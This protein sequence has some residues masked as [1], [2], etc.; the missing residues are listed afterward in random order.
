MSLKI[1]KIILS[2]FD[3]LKDLYEK[4]LSLK[5]DK[6]E[7]HERII[8]FYNIADEA[9]KN[10]V[11]K[12][13]HE[14]DIPEFFVIFKK[15]NN[16]PKA[17]L[18]FIPSTNHC[19]YAYANLEVD[20]DGTIN[21]CCVYSENTN[22]SIYNSTLS[23]FH[24]SQLMKSLRT[25]LQNNQK[26]KGCQKCW[27]IEESGGESMRMAA[28]YKF[29]DLYYSLDYNSIDS[30]NLKILDLKMGNNCNLSCRICDP[31]HSSSLAD[32][33]L[34]NGS[35]SREKHFTIIKNSKWSLQNTI[36]EQLIDVSKNIRYFDLY[37]GEPLM[38]KN[39]YNYLNKLIEL[40]IAKEIKLDYNSNG[41]FYSDSWFNIWQHFK[42]VKISFSIDNI[43]KRFELERNGS[44]WQK[45]Q[46]NIN[47]FIKKKSDKFVVDI[48]PTISIMNVYYL[49]ELLNWIASLQC[50]VP[51][52]LNN[53]VY[54]PEW[55]SVQ[56][57]TKAAKDITIQ[58]LEK[59]QNS[60]ASLFP[61]IEMLKN[62]AGVE[63]NEEFVNIMKKLDS[64]RNQ[65]FLLT[66]EEIAVAMGYK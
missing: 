5:K 26:P 4:L 64:E 61:V 39:H 6:F 58:K 10:F 15:Q 65:N 12:L 56:K 7:D 54:H 40:D 28:K 23:E 8:F 29:K 57:I 21:P 35:L 37:G 17:N 51:P 33:N 44:S 20:T 34:K 41:T 36:Y 27:N 42:Q 2:D 66:H 46:E 9:L 48:F 25:Q 55:L 16:I 3:K 30:S 45:V 11:E 31:K 19:L 18:D 38:V 22:T 50:S 13:L 1:T 14:L 24:Q 52:T 43:E 47:K 59:Y 60:Y 32:L 49:P 62:T 63:N 53:F